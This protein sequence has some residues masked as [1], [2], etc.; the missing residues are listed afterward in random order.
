MKAPFLA[1]LLGAGLLAACGGSAAPAAPSAPAGSPAKP[2]A[3]ATA[4]SSA[5]AVS[6]PASAGVR[7]KVNLTIASSASFLPMWVAME[8]GIFQKNGLDVEFKSVA[9]GPAG[10]AALLGG[11]VQV[12]DTGGAQA[13]NAA[14]SG[15][16]VL[17]EAITNPNYNF[18]IEVPP[19]IKAP[20]D[21]KGKAFGVINV[22]GTDDLALR[23]GLKSLGIDPDKDVRIS[24]MGS[25]QAE[26]AAMLSGAVQGG[27]VTPPENL[28]VE[29]AGWHV[30]LDMTKSGIVTANNCIFTTRS[31]ANNNRATVQKV[32]DS[33][34]QA[35][36]LIKKDKP[37]TISAMRKYLKQDNQ[38]ILDATYSFYSGSVFPAL[39]YPRAEN[40]AD[41]KAVLGQQVPAA[42]DFDVARMLDPSFVQS[43]ADRGLDKG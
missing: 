42:L 8:S 17:V 5:P 39:P 22:G 26:V 36:A 38:R 9:G 31:Y 12:A 18:Y 33:T 14:V 25:L 28:T 43:A 15:A 16:D 21:V 6:A 29:D 7:P 3:P 24:S 2:S 34:V 10:T 20:A 19:A 41:A 4:S 32:I 37:A 35:I 11:D 40:F 13:L 23:I 30:L 1:A 27:L